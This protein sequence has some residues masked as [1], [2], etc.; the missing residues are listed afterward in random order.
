M[1]ESVAIGPADLFCFRWGIVTSGRQGRPLATYENHYWVVD[2][3]YFTRIECAAT[4][5]V[6]FEND[7][8]ELVCELG[9]THEFVALD[10]MA[11]VG[12]RQAARLTAAPPLWNPMGTRDLWPTLILVPAAT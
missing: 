4:V 3:A 1:H 7:R 6:R 12:R 10:G 9:P 8:G 2:G 11:Y 5:L